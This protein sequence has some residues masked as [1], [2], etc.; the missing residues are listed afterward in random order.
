M[1]ELTM[2]CSAIPRRKCARGFTLIEILVVVA[3]IALLVALLIPSLARARNQAKSVQCI[4][5][6]RQVG[7]GFHTYALAWR[8]VLPAPLYT[9]YAAAGLPKP[10]W[11]WQVMLWKDLVKHKPVPSDFK[12]NN[13]FSYLRQTLFICPSAHSFDGWLLNDDAQMYGYAMNAN[14]P[15]APQK[16]VIAG[17]AIVSGEFKSLGRVKT[18]PATLLA[19]D[20]VAVSVT[21]GSAGNKSMIGGPATSVF[22]MAARSDQQNRH[23]GKVNGLMCDGSVIAYRWVNEAWTIDF[24][25]DKWKRSNSGGLAVPM[26]PLEADI[27]KP[28][29][30]PTKV[31]L[32]WYG[33]IL[34]K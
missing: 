33:R 18:Q 7:A 16:V 6:L 1:D 4:A 26:P 3:I 27:T 25:S 15:Q 5:N 12:G 30:W 11:P 24:S 23:Y 13:Q 2:T 29:T 20:G 9:D 17:P 31:Q 10:Q 34:P 22:D 8:D 32:F 28:E 14:L 19:A 21:A